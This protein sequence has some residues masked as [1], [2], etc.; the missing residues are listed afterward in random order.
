MIK[1]GINEEI[2]EQLNADLGQF[3]LAVSCSDYSDYI[4]NPK[5]RVNL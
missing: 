5:Y 1:K 3:G 2:H 4:E